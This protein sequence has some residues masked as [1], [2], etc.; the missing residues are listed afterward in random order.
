MVVDD[1]QLAMISTAVAEELRMMVPNYEFKEVMSHQDAL[2]LRK[3]LRV[4]IVANVYG[5]NPDQMY[6]NPAS[7]T[8]QFR[9]A[10]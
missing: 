9:V 5:L 6:G 8:G 4:A 2:R 1:N 10:A 7:V 3:S